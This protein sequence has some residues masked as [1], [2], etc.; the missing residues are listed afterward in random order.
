MIEHRISLD[1]HSQPQLYLDYLVNEMKNHYAQNISDW[2]NCSSSDESRFLGCSI[3]WIQEDAKI[4][5]D[6]VYR[7]ENNQQ[8]TKDTGFDLGQTYY[9]TRIVIVE[10]RLIQAGLRLATVINKLVQ[11][12]TNDNKSNNICFGTMTLMVVILSQSILILALLSYSFL[13]R[14][15]TTIITQPHMF[16]DKKEYLVIP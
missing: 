1:F 9:N 15:T 3:L 6:A 14:K 11:S 2:T 10:Q 13:R 7:D 8:I 12:K 16:K 5:C 4:D